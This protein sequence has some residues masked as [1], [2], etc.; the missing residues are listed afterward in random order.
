[1][2]TRIFSTT[3][4]QFFTAISTKTTT[5]FHETLG[6]YSHFGFSSSRTRVP[7]CFR[8]APH[9]YCALGRKSDCDKAIADEIKHDEKD[10]AYNIV[11]VYAFCGDADKAFAWLDK[12]VAYRDP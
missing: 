4:R 8:R 5:R 7:L 3:P 2:T 1:M 11:Y 10:G 6:N 12:A 9:A